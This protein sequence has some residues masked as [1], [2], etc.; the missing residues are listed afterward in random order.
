M[1]IFSES[2]SNINVYCQYRAAAWLLPVGACG[3][4]RMLAIMLDAAKKSGAGIGCVDLHVVD[5]ATIAAINWRYLECSGPTNIIS[6]P[7]EEQFQGILALSADA[8]SR[9]CRLYGQ[10]SFTHLT[11]LLAHGFG[12]LAGYDHGEAMDLVSDSCFKTVM[13]NRSC[14]K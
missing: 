10:E 9:E 8:F 11:R 1:T 4:R 3:L 12:H 2:N 5:D 14:I 13:E 6:F 7:G